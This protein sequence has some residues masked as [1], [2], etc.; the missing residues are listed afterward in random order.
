M[1]IADGAIWIWERVKPLLLSL[2]VKE[3]KIVEA[4]DYYHAAEH[5]ASI[6]RIFTNKQISKEKK[7]AWMNELR[8]DLYNGR[9]DQLIEKVSRLAKGRKR[10]LKKTG[11]LQKKQAHNAVSF[12]TAKSLALR[13]WN[14]GVCHPSINLRLKCPSCFWNVQ[15]V[16]KLIFLRGIFLAGRW[17]IM[18]QN[19]SQKNLR[20]VTLGR[21]A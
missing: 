8:N 19:L 21:A 9:I 14:C 20:R 16:E 17:N 10:V 13:Q 18:I 15:N 7:K 6:M 4:V 11:I 2:E 3:E 1:F 12:S 5:I